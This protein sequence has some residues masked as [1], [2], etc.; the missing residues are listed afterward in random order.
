MRHRVVPFLALSVL[1][2]SPADAQRALA[3]AEYTLPETGAVAVAVRRRSPAPHRPATAPP[4][5]VP[6]RP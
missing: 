4:P 1:F 6:P 3:I 5:R 2:V